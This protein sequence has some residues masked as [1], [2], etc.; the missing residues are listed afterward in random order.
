MTKYLMAALVVAVASAVLA[1]S[2][3][4]EAQLQETTTTIIDTRLAPVI[5]RDGE[6][7]VLI[8]LRDLDEL[9]AVPI[10]EWTRELVLGIDFDLRARHAQEVQASVRS[11]LGKEDATELTGF[12]TMP[13]LSA[14][15]T[16]SG[17]EKLRN[18]PDVMAIGAAEL[19]SLSLVESAA[20]IHAGA[21]H[22]AGYDGSGVN[23]AVLDSGIDTD[24]PDLMDSIVE[25]ICFIQFTNCGPFGHPAEDVNGHGTRVS[26]VITSN[27]T[28]QGVPLG[29][30]PEAGIYAYRVTVGSTVNASAVAASLEDI[31]LRNYPVRFVN[32]SFSLGQ[33]FPGICTA[34]DYPMIELE[35]VLIRLFGDVLP[36]AAS[37]NSADH[38]NM[39]FPACN[40]WVVSVGAVFDADV[41]VYVWDGLC[42][43]STTYPDRMACWSNSSDVLDL[44]AP[45]CKITTTG[46]GGGAATTCG[47][48]H[49]SP[50]A[51]AV[52]ALLKDAQPSRT[53]D[54]ILERMVATGEWVYDPYAPRWTPRVDARVA[55]L[56]DDNADWDGDG[57]RNGS[58]YTLDV[59]AGATRNPLDSEDY[60]DVSIPKD[61]VIDLSNDISGVIDH[62]SPA[63]APPYDVYYDRGPS[64]GPFFYNH[65]PRDGVI[66][67]SNDILSVID[68]YNPGG[69]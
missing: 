20:L 46:L 62:Y 39:P 57:C 6:I 35:L 28:V 49:S 16:A 21:V 26:G 44:L 24:H 50:H 42:T 1:L 15:I 7:K 64:I 13:G 14:T 48:S 34:S 66:D 63:G 27:G 31:R 3:P 10:A 52:A 9:M 67:L 22:A 12:K 54:Q 41:G 51:A 30:A 5:E 43:N 25:E 65:G 38:T 37:G 32:M 11:V 61:G 18:H 69:C 58:E 68:Q 47:T 53:A 60:Y 23:V 4:A 40:S 36:F 17:L 33:R 2:F 45:G 55:L 19:G 29:I 56:V 59:P 8:S